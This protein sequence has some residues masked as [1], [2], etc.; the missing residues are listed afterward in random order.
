MLLNAIH[1]LYFLLKILEIISIWTINTVVAVVMAGLLKQVVREI[2]M[3]FDSLF[4]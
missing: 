3:F 2:N 4:P 1:Y